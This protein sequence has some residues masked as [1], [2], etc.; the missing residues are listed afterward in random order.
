LRLIFSP[1]AGEAPRSRARA[2]AHRHSLARNRG[3]SAVPSSSVAP[4]LLGCVVAAAHSKRARALRSSPQTPGSQRGRG[5]RGRR[6][7]A[8]ATRCDT[9]AEP[10][11]RRTPRARECRRV[12]RRQGQEQALNR[13][14]QEALQHCWRRAGQ[15]QGGSCVRLVRKSCTQLGACGCG[16]AQKKSKSRRKTM[17]D[18][19]VSFGAGER[20]PR[21]A[22]L[23]SFSHTDSRRAQLQCGCL[24][25][26]IRTP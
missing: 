24:I 15:R 16:C 13:H 4:A 25:A 12:T 17:G 5:G 23:A 10:N 2:L 20:S 11:F 19:R 1:M 22:S 3:V 6:F 26:T 18:K 8:R 7:Q 14:L 21:R 9:P